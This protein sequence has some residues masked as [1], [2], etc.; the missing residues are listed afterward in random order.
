MQIH[1]FLK[2]PFTYIKLV[3]AV[4]T[5]SHDSAIFPKTYSVVP[6]SRHLL[7]VFP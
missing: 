4:I 1:N 2:V 3:I 6:S 7:Y 5:D